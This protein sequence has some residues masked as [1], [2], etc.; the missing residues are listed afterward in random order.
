MKAVITV[1]GMVQGVGFRPFVAGLAESMDICGSVRNSGGIV[2]IECDAETGVLGEFVRR[3]RFLA[4]RG[5]RVLDVRVTEQHE[6]NMAGSQER[7]PAEKVSGSLKAMY[8]R[9]TSSLSCRRIS[10]CAR[11]AGGNCFL[12]PTDGMVIR[13]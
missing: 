11:T 2:I 1:L 7:Q 9:L 6:D 3:L 10:V 8:S 13:I 12:F 4:P 5:A